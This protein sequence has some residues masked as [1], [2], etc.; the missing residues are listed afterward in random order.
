MVAIILIASGSVFAQ[1]YGSSAEWV[2]FYKKNPAQEKINPKE[3]VKKSNVAPMMNMSTHYGSNNFFGFDISVGKKVTYGL[4]LSIYIGK[5][6]VG[7]EFTNFHWSKYSSDVYEKISA[8][9]ISLYGIVGYKPIPNLII[10]GNLGMG[11]KLN[12]YNAYDKYKILG[13]NGFYYTTTDAG[14]TLLV[15]GSVQYI[16]NKVSPYVGYDTFNGIKVGVGYN[17]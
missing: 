16:F 4:G 11:T 8:P 17:F 15:G 9:N 2:T 13:T 6:S 14:T 3:H 10:Q 1:E 12:Y 5:S 7:Q